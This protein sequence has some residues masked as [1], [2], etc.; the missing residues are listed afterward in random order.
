MLAISAFVVVLLEVTHSTA[1]GSDTSEECSINWDDW[2]I[3]DQ[4]EEEEKEMQ[5]HDK[6]EKQ[7]EPKHR[8][9]DLR[10]TMLVVDATNE[11]KPI[12]KMVIKKDSA[13]AYVLRNVMKKFH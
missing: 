2:L 4:E 12:P 6:H 11:K 5:A 9:P 7:K 1:S 13:E 8:V 3:F 10:Y